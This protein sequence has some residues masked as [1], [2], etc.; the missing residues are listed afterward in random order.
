MLEWSTDSITPEF[1]RKIPKSDLHS[2][3]GRSGN[4]RYISKCVGQK[5]S[6]PPKNFSSMQDMQDWFTENIKKLTPGAEGQMLRW[7]AGFQQAAEDGIAVMALLFSFS[8]TGMVGGMENFKKIL[9]NYHEELCPDTIFIPQLTFDRGNDGEWAASIID[10]VSDYHFFKAIDVCNNEFAQPIKNLKPL[11][12]RAKQ[13]GFRLIAHVGELGTADDV[14]EAVEELEL[15]EVNHGIAAADSDEVMHFLAD[16]RIQL[17]ICP[18]SNVMLKCVS[19]YKHHPIK[20]L[21]GAGVPVTINTDDLLVFNQSV[22]EEYYNLY[23]AEV[24]TLQ[25]LDEI[26]MIGLG[27][28]EK[29]A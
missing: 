20:K 2:H 17:N 26:R 25:E 6:G 18:T 23:S 3:A 29:Y 12:R 9:D 22:S 15:D 24:L 16:N 10:E 7:K 21:Y 19:D 27:A 1:F 11:Y 14:R 13:N 8:E 28:G 5:I 4:G